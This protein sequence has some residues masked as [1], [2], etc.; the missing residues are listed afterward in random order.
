MASSVVIILSSGLC[1]RFGNKKNFI[2]GSLLFGIGTII[3]L[4][5][6]SM[7]QLV[8]SRIVMG[9]GAGVV[10]PATYGIIGEHFEKKKYS[11]VFAAFAVVQIVFSGLGSLAGGYLPQIASWQ[12]IFIILLS[13]E[14]LS[15]L[16][17]FLNLPDNAPVMQS[18]HFR[19]REHLLMIIAILLTTLGIEYAYHQQYLL[20][21]FSATLLFCVVWKDIK[22]KNILLPKEFIS[23]SLLRNLCLQVFLLGAFY[24]VC[25]A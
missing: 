19:F 12:T 15:F 21:I 5:C 23:D 3:A 8:I 7:P 14:L 4:L 6:N 11:A 10:V 18:E 25:L 1:R 24:N 13:L 9:L 16:L 2:I 22:G 20:L 17:V